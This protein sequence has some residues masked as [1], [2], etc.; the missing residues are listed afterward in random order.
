MEIAWADRTGETP[1]VIV[2]EIEWNR[3]T[4]DP[5]VETMDETESTG[6]ETTDKKLTAVFDGLATNEAV[7]IDW[8]EALLRVDLDDNW[9]RIVL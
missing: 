6:T 3:T 9:E 5:G 8:V 4:D 1:A 2:R 7:A